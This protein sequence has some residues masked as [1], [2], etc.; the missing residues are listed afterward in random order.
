LWVIPPRRSVGLHDV[1]AI[2]AK[3]HHSLCT[4]T[5][6]VLVQAVTRY[7][8]CFL[9]NAPESDFTASMIGLRMFVFI[10]RPDTSF[11]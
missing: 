4:N 1:G 10:S 9:A 7:A 2:T 3:L 5:W 8:A 11:D 6:G